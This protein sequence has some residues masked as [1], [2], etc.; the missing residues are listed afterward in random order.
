M[1]TT[2]NIDDQLLG[3]AKKVALS[4]N[5]T[6]SALVET[7]LREMLSKQRPKK[8]KTAVKLVTYKGNGLKRGVDLDDSAA[9]LE[10]ME[11]G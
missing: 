8:G 5:S 11:G 2:V 10:L 1:R 4:S 6:L 9:L 3:Q 7:A